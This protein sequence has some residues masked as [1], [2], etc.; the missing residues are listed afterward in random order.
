M[1]EREG[2][3]MAAIVSRAR[4]VVRVPLQS[5]HEGHDQGAEEEV[6]HSLIAS[7]NRSHSSSDISKIGAPSAI[8][9]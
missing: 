4:K 9:R 3:C 5:E 6:P 1:A 2:H 8:G 7:M